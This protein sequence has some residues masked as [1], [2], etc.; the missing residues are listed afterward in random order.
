MLLWNSSVKPKDSSHY[1]TDKNGKE[2]LSDEAQ[3][4]A[5]RGFNIGHDGQI[6]ARLDKNRG[7]ERYI[8]AILDFNGNTGRISQKDANNEA[9]ISAF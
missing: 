6:Y 5:A 8:D 2:R 3:R 4:L 9:E 7:G 1:T